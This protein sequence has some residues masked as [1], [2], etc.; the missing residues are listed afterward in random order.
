MAAV[1][2][3]SGCYTLVADEV[4]YPPPP[5]PPHTH[6]VK[7]FGCL[8]KRYINAINYYYYYMCR[9]QGLWKTTRPIKYV[10]WMNKC[11]CKYMTCWVSCPFYDWVAGKKQ[12]WRWRCFSEIFNLKHPKWLDNKGET[13]RKKMLGT[14]LFMHPHWKQLKNGGGAQ[15]KMLCGH[16]PHS[17]VCFVNG[18][19]IDRRDIWPTTCH[20]AWNK[21]TYMWMCNTHTRVCIVIT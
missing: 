15:K 10:C 13:L 18:Q 19:V 17:P 12:Q 2:H 20:H 16:R 11:K 8:E 21:D 9:H 7:C 5:P 1:H 14:V 3:P 4:S 6:Y